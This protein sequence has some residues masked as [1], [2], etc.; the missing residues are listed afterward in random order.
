MLSH[1]LRTPLTPVMAALDTLESD[2]P[3]S[4]ESKNSLSMIRRN[5][6][7]KAN[8]STIS[9]ISPNHQDKLQLRFG[10][11]DAHEVINNVVELPPGAQA[12]NLTLNLNW[13]AGARH[14]SATRQSSKS[15]GTAQERD[16]VH[17]DHG[18]SPFP[19]PI[20]NHSCSPSLCRHRHR[21]EPE[22]MNRIF[23]P[24]EQ[25]ERAFQRRYGGL[26]LGLAISKSLAKRTAAPIAQSEGRDAIHF[27]LTMRTVPAPRGS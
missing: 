11:L 26:G 15:F 2:G 9:W 5:V 14:V 12:R 23:D 4:S 21:I 18:R 10:T 17:G 25:G 16:Q 19:H 20:R 8:S 27:H 6:S 22:I 7:W 1:E 3:R 24:F 13:R